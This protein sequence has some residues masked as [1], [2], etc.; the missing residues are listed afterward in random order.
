MKE[1]DSRVTFADTKPVPTNDTPEG[2]DM[3]EQL[4]AF[5]GDPAIK[6]KYLARVRAHAAADRLT[7][8]T[9]WDGGKGCAVGCTL[10][11][12]D[13][14]RYPTEL[15]LP[16]W[17]ARLEDS[18]F[19]GLPTELAM[20]W[21]ERFLSAIPV[22]ADLEPVRHK[23]ALAR[24]GLLIELQESHLGKH[25][26][27]SDSVIRQAVEALKVV[28]ACHEAELGANSRT[29]DWRSAARSA[30]SAARSAAES[31]AESAARSAVWSAARSAESA[32]RS[33]ARSAAWVTESEI[34]L[35]LLAGAE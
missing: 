14:S 6:E 17:L 13:H 33:A 21:P 31:A 1:V 29:V 15:G 28:A 25:G 32:A 27:G 2:T 9:G 11:A 8:G 4:K 20:T 16:E 24:F 18:I 22:G 10:E 23:L 35:Q 3:T 12:Y 26:D 34:L 5:H 30:E 19:E 7:Q